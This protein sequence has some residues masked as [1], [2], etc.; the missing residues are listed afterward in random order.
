MSCFVGH[1]VSSWSSKS[2]PSYV[3]NQPCVINR[4][5][6][7][8]PGVDQSLKL[9]KKSFDLNF[10]FMVKCHFWLN[11]TL[12]LNIFPICLLFNHHSAEKAAFNFSTYL[13]VKTLLKKFNVLDKL[14]FACIPK[15]T[16]VCFVFGY[17]RTA[18]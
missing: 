16:V 12:W 7:G 15:K 4:S 6:A 10:K 11:L 13:K 5:L 18:D 1:P 17:V 8:V 9:K 3:G 14:I 2:L